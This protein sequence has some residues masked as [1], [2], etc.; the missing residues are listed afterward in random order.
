[1]PVQGRG[2]LID[3]V[4]LPPDLRYLLLAIDYL[5]TEADWVELAGILN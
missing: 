5:T 2:F 4:Q 3:S 1:M